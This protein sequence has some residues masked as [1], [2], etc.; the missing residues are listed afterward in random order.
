MKKFFHSA[1]SVN[2][3]FFLGLLFSAGVV[4]LTYWKPANIPWTLLSA[5]TVSA[6]FAIFSIIQ[7]KLNRQLAHKVKELN[8]RDFK[9]KKLGNAVTNSGSSIIITDEL[10]NIEYANN[11]F[12][13]TTG[14]CL[15][16]IKGRSLDILNPKEAKSA[17]EQQWEQELLFDGWEGDVL[18]CRKCGSSFWSAVSISSV[19]DSQGFVTNFVISCIDITELKEANSKMQIMALYDPLTGLANRRLF[20]DRLEQAVRAAKRDRKKIALMFL[21]LDQFKRINDTLGHDAGDILLTTVSN[22]LKECVREKDTVA[23]LGGD[24]FTV[25]LTD[26]EDNLSVTPVAHQIL[27]ALKKP[28]KLKKHEVIVSTSIGITL[29]PTDGS[30]ADSLMKNADLAL[31]RAKEQGRDC[32]HFFTEELNASALRQLVLE[33]ELRHAL[34]YDEFTLHFQ[35]QVNLRNEHVVSVEALLRWYHPTKGL[36][37]P[38]AFIPVAE[39][40]G[41]IVPIGRWVLK[42]AC[43]QMKML[44]DLTG[45]DLKIAVNLSTRQ[46]DDPDLEDTIADALCQTGLDPKW[47]E[48]EVTESMLM[49]DIDLVIEKLKRLKATG[50][51]ITIDD[52]GSGYSSLSYLKK[53]PVD[54]LKV[55]REF[56]RDIPEDL[57]D[58]E[59][60]SAVIA[61][62]HKLNLKVIAEGVEDIDQRDFLMINKCDYAQGYFYSKPLPF[63]DLYQYLNN[64]KL[65]QTA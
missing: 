37:S 40:T 9:L 16:E 50:V 60:T 38:D 13:K 61:V 20:I 21:D 59:I 51:S 28:V 22:R 31:Y 65:A 15:T 42:N 17:L 55:D 32:Y 33:Q 45:V 41:L 7:I 24:E 4:A 27:R 34:Q 1:K 64:V 48:L 2:F 29:A 62:A 8:E 46:F 3:S 56:V 36:V 54:I 44:Q 35:P 43:M 39:E 19:C 18:S 58:M 25:L 11:K 63:E 23:R 5:V 57:N 49:G 10:G 12:V 14:Y 26:V 52:F 53:L 6:A 30:T 47:L